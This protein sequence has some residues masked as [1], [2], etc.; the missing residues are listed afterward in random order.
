MP[1]ILNSSLNEG[2]YRI[3]QKDLTDWGISVGL[4]IL[5]YS[6]VLAG[7]YWSHVVFRTIARGRKYLM[8]YNIE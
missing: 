5:G 1:L 7:A 2:F 3:D 4:D 8:D 6:P